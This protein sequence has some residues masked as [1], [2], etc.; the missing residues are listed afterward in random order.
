MNDLMISKV[1]HHISHVC[2]SDHPSGVTYWKNVTWP[3]WYLSFIALTL[4]KILTSF[5]WVFFCEF[6]W[7]N[8][9][10][11]DRMWMLSVSWCIT[12]PHCVSDN[13]LVPVYE[14]RRFTDWHL[15]IFIIYLNKWTIKSTN[16]KVTIDRV[17]SWNSICKIKAPNEDHRGF[18]VTY[19]YCC[20]NYFFIEIIEF[21][22]LWIT[23]KIVFV[24]IAL[25]IMF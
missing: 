14:T 24:I 16:K 12:T 18:S 3:G 13:S 25:L 11:I 5:F 2:Q 15:F 20:F 8:A 21:S 17:S 10:F 23:K 4:I 7:W 9:L 6:T 22:E 1:H 19:S